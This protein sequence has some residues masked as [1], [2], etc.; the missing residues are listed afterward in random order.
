[1]IAAPLVSNYPFLFFFFSGSR[2][3]EPTVYRA[4]Q[5]HI[6]RLQ[7]WF[8]RNLFLLIDQPPNLGDARIGKDMIDAAMLGEHLRKGG[9]NALPQRDVNLMK[10]KASVRE[11]LLQICN[12]RRACCGV[13]VEDGDVGFRF[14]LG[15]KCTGDA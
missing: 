3:G 5:I 15:G 13:D 2:C 14:A 1:M 6:Q 4:H 7:L 11:F 9:G 8:T 12:D 10:A